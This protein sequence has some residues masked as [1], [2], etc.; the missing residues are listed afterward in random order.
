LP[1]SA[2][3]PACGTSI[4]QDSVFNS[5]FVLN[6]HTISCLNSPILTELGTMCFALYLIASS[7]AGDNLW[8]IF[9]SWKY[10]LHFIQISPHEVHYLFLK[11]TS[12][13]QPKRFNCH[14]VIKLSANENTFLSF[15]T[16]QIKFAYFLESRL[17]KKYQMIFWHWY[18]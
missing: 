16:K 1:T 13:L 15:I 4:S 17:C 8:V 5:K 9:Y 10:Y 14:C 18:F 12:L 3:I 11:Q 7:S 2:Q 6:I